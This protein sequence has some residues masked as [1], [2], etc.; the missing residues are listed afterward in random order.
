M[1]AHFCY[2]VIFPMKDYFLFIIFFCLQFDSQRYMGTARDENALNI[3]LEFVPGGSIASL[4]NKFGP[5][6][7]LVK[8]K[9]RLT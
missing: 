5:F 8:G 9:R 7:E 1:T 2:N 6:P 4:L 3:F